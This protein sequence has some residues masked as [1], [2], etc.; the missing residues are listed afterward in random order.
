[1]TISV[2]AK[3]V[4]LSAWISIPACATTPSGGG[5]IT[6]AKD[7]VIQAGETA[8]VAITEVESAVAL[9]TVASAIAALERIAGQ[10]GVAFV[11]CV[12][13]RIVGESNIAFA[14]SNEQ[15]PV[16]MRKIFN[17]REWLARHPSPAEP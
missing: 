13:D 8:G 14:R 16:A 12:V 1:M 10:Y 11:S 6:V 17:G 15:D 2:A 4:L 7:C 3:L 9:P 5:P